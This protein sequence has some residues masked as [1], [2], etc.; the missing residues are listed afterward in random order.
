M[1]ILSFELKKILRGA[2]GISRDRVPSALSLSLSLNYGAGVLA[3]QKAI[4]DWP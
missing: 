2:R 1:E 3:G 4:R